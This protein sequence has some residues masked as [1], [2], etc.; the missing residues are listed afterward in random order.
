MRKR[1]AADPNMNRN[2]MFKSKYGITVQQ[3]DAMLAGQGGKC[4]MCLT[5]DP[6]D[7]NGWCIDHCHAS[8]KVR[9]ILCRRCNL[10]LGYAGDNP[11]TLARAIQ[12]LNQ[13]P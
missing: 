9:G 6:G 2:S 5:E 4:P 7:Y 12:Y 1:R 13:G 11:Q 8:G 3:R 10:L